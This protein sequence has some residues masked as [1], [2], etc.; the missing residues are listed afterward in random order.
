[1][2]NERKCDALGVFVHVWLLALGRTKRAATSTFLYS[3]LRP[4]KFWV[5]NM[6][7]CELDIRAD[8]YF[9]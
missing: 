2:I 6:S 1:M 9:E 7:G 4:L 3:Q 8:Q 5:A